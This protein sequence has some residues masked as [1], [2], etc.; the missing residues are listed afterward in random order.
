MR[1]SCSWPL[2][3]T[4]DLSICPCCSFPRGC[5][6]SEKPTNPTMSKQARIVLYILR[7]DIRLSDNPV[8][9]A[10][11]QQTQRA[12]SRKP[13]PSG[14]RRG[15]DDSLTSEHGGAPF[16]H[17]LPVYVFP[18]RQIETSG[19]L[20]SPSDKS[21]Y[22]E[23]RSQF[24]KVWRTGPHRAKFI[25]QG[26]WGLKQRL[27]NL[28]CGSGLEM[29]VGHVEEVVRDFINSY[30]LKDGEN[31]SKPKITGVWMTSDD[32]TEERDEV[33]AVRKVAA[34]HDIPF[35]LW[36]DEK[37]FIDEYVIPTFYTTTARF[38]LLTFA[39]EIFHSKISLISPMFTRHIASHSNRFGN[40][41]GP[42]FPR[43]QYSRHSRQT[44][45]R[46]KRHSKYLP[47]G[48]VSSVRL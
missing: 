4:C 17:F 3:N 41:H 2:C 43:R 35:K 28:G 12:N 38:K 27:E 14:E 6:A 42:S 1:R 5:T 15:R 40:A 22:S 37:F 31:G 21:P 45:P 48:M 23:A 44:Y 24:A 26:V 11:A 47:H 10:A 18:P 39:V 13:S 36:A 33:K 7:R 34:E 19:F 20:A 25:G 32:G 16:T 29:R 9:H 46:K 8:F 30:S